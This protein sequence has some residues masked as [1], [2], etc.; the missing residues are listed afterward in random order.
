MFNISFNFLNGI[1]EQSLADA[2][3]PA[4]LTLLDYHYLCLWLVRSLHFTNLSL[5]LIYP[6]YIIFMIFRRV[7]K[8]ALGQKVDR[9]KVAAP[10]FVT[11]I[12]RANLTN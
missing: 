7:G 11:F 9:E 3:M 10:T 1:S 4:A 6:R 12:Q 2:T 8:S 5:L